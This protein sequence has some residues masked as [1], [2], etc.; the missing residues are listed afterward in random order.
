MGD[1][2][3]LN[4]SQPSGT[5]KSIL[6]RARSVGICVAGIDSQ[7]IGFPGN[8]SVLLNLVHIQWCGLIV[9][10]FPVKYRHHLLNMKWY[11]R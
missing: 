10:F 11:I 7:N 1:G 3:D 2:Y 9:E 8:P 6:V 5:Q 4:R